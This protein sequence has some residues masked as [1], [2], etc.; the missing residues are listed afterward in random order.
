[1]NS[2][3]FCRLF[4]SFALLGLFF[5]F[6]LIDLLFIFISIFVFLWVLCV[7]SFF[8][9][10]NDNK[11]GWKEVGRMWETWR[12]EKT[13][14]SLLYRRNSV[15]KRFKGG[16]TALSGFALCFLYK[17]QVWSSTLQNKQMQWKLRVR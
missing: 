11:V 17:M 4:V 6:C 14:Q 7:F 1:M 5:F 10:K 16:Y 3:E 15:L 12:G 13:D 8:L 9:R 2:L